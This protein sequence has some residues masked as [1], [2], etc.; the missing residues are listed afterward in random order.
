MSLG[1]WWGLHWTCRLLLVIEPASLCWCYQ[2]MSMGDLS[3]FCSLPQFL[4]WFIDFLV[5][6]IHIL[7]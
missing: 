2:C 1:F 4:Q 3:I 5:D 6:V 7:C